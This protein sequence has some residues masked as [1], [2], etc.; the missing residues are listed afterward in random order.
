MHFLVHCHI[1]MTM[2]LYQSIRKVEKMQDKCATKSYT[3]HINNKDHAAPE[4]KLKK[5]I[6]IKKEIG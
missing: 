1:G 6:K 2:H 3:T 5:K 4:R